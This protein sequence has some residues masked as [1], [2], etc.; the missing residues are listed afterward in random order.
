MPVFRVR[1]RTR[2]GE[3][4]S[5]R[6]E[7]PAESNLQAWLVAEQ[8]RAESVR[9]LPLTAWPFSR[10]PWMILVFPVLCYGLYL[11]AVQTVFSGL[12]LLREP[13]TRSAYERLA[14]EGVTV[15]GAVTLERVV[16]LRGARRRTLE[17]AFVDPAG[18]RRQGLLAPIPGNLGA[19]R[20]DL[21]LLPDALPAPGS[22]VTVT[23]LPDKPSIH[24]PFEVDDHLLERFDELSRVLRRGLG[25]LAALAPVLAWMVWNVLVRTG[26]HYVLSPSEPR[27]LL[28]TRG[29]NPF[30]EDDEDDDEG[31]G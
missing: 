3:P 18:L 21:R 23:F 28:I 24:A 15:T 10:L 12:D 14:R 26:S 6:F 17:Y 16:S 5:V 30:V 27:L 9:Q 31:E 19:S 2:H 8:A 11:S 25:L 20:H 1:G 29:E 22:E 4:F 13:V 7:A